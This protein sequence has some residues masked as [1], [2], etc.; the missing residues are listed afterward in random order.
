M[1]AN[2]GSLITALGNGCV[3]AVGDVPKL[4]E[5]LLC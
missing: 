3:P 4:K 2:Y 5:V 1:S